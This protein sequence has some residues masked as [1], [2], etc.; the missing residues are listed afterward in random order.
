MVLDTFHARH[1]L[2]R[3]SKGLSLV[4]AFD[5]PLQMNHAVAFFWHIAS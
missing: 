5:C 1:I 3:D 2:C 4:V